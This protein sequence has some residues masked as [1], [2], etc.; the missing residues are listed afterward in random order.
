MTCPVNPASGVN[1]TVDDAVSTVH[2]PSPATTFVVVVHEGA[3]SPAPQILNDE[4]DTPVPVSFSKGDTTMSPS[5]APVAVSAPELGDAGIWMVAVIEDEYVWP[6]R[7]VPVYE[8][9]VATPAKFASGTNVTS[10]V[11]VSSVQVPSPGTVPVV[12]KQLGAVSAVSHNFMRAEDS[13]EPVSFA[14][15][16]TDSA[17][18]IEP[19]MTSAEG[20]GATG[21]LIV[22]D[23]VDDPHVVGGVAG[24]HVPATELHTT[25]DTGVAAPLNVVNGTNETDPADRVQVP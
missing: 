5:A 20:L 7:S 8:M 2:V 21:E 1:T 3:E 14:S 4:P 25:Y 12:D 17:C 10:P 9:G 24:A 16:V 22:T 13:P 15:G 23:I 11:P 18:P 19:L 6:T